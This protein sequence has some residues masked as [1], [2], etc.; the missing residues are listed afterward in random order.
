MRSRAGVRCI[1]IAV[2]LTALSAVTWPQAR[3]SPYLF[4]YFTDN[5]L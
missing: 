4:T 3:P 2:I 5:G 1:R